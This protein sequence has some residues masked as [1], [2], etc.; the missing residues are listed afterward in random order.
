MLTGTFAGRQHT[1]QWRLHNSKAMQKL[2]SCL[3]RFCKYKAMLIKVFTSSVLFSFFSLSR[4][5]SLLC[6]LFSLCSSPGNIPPH[7]LSSSLEGRHNSAPQREFCRLF[8]FFKQTPS[9]SPPA[10]STTRW[11]WHQKAAYLIQML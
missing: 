5:S 9:T 8:F 11:K 3:K 2:Y 10:Q 4:L 6:P 7:F 1:R